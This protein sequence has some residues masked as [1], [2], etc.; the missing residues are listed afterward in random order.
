MVTA[1]APWKES[2][3][4]PRQHLNKQRDITLPT[5]IRIVQAVVFPVVMWIWELDHKEDRVP[6]IWCFQIVVLEK[7]LESPLDCREIKPV[8]PK[9]NQPWILIGRTDAEAPILWP[10]DVKDSLEKTLML[11]KDGAQEKG[12]T[13][14]EMVWIASLNQW[15]WV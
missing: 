8:N 10:P 7:A 1:A 2:Y 11:G 9:G 12:V 5:R 15:E 3:D 13:E 6:M 14:E 4:K